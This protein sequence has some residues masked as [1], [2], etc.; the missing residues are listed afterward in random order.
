MSK[1]IVEKMKEKF[2]QM[3]K[4]SHTDEEVCL[5]LFNIAHDDLALKFGMVNLADMV[6]KPAGAT[7]VTTGKSKVTDIKKLAY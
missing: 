5:A 1:E 6:S 7:Q 3:A 2:A 4:A